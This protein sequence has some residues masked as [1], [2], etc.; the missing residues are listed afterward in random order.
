MLEGMIVTIPNT[1]LDTVV[2]HSATA[3]K[4]T[5]ESNNGSMKG[6]DKHGRLHW[7]MRWDV[8]KVKEV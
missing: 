4:V 7:F 3:V 5:H 1:N 2:A 8:R 6:C